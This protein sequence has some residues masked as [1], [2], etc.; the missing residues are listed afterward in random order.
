MF[1]ANLFQSGRQQQ[2]SELWP[3]HHVQTYHVIK[4]PHLFYWN[5]GLVHLIVEGG[6]KKQWVT[7][8]LLVPSELVPEVPVT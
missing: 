8:N 5:S 7:E 3:T 2:Q 6:E 4:R 1:A